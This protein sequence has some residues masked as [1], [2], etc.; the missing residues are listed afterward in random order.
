MWFPHW[1]A[2][3]LRPQGVPIDPAFRNTLGR[4]GVLREVAPTQAEPSKATTATGVIPQRRSA[5]RFLFRSLEGLPACLLALYEKRV[6]HLAL[7]VSMS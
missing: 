3:R 5:L 4:G 2:F 7:L 1:D 6:E